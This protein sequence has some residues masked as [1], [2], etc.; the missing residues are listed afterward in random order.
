M[1]DLKKIVENTDEV[2]SNLEKRGF[3]CS[4]L[5]KI[6]SLDSKRKEL[7]AVVEKNRSDLK[8]KAKEIGSLKKQGADASVIMNEVASL[9]EKNSELDNELSNVQDQQKDYLMSIPNLLADETPVGESE[10]NN[11][12]ILRKGTPRDFDFEVKDHV[13]L[14]EKLGGLDFEKASEITGARFVVYKGLLAR[15]ERALINFMIDSHV[16]KGY[17]EIIP[18]SIVHKRCLEGTGQL[19][20][21]SEDLFKIENKDWYL[22]PTA[23]VPL[24]NLKRDELFERKEL[25]L[26][27]CAFTPCFR[28]E[29][30]SYGK[31]TRGLVRLHQFHKVELVNI[32]ESK[33][34]NMAHED[35]IAR[36]SSILDDLKLPYRAMVLCSG[37]IGFGAKK[38]IDLEV[39]LP[40]QNKYREISSVSNCGDFQSRRANIRYRNS[41]GKPEYA[42]TL[43]GSGLA[44]GRTLVAILENYQNEDGSITVPEVLRGYM[45]GLEIIPSQK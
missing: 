7:I 15:M 43:N 31:D 26:N 23:E 16:D 4:L 32:V 39:W 22:I 28:S 27:Y 8:N 14:G 34:S 21:F 19:P 20:K 37:D 5:D 9:K 17:Q 30:G 38:T 2:K 25:P 42:H 11:L 3:D 10:D 24:T 1:L 33:Q 44:V 36:A 40:A 41:E 29:A 45:G 18:P 35:M 12:E 6:I 13:E